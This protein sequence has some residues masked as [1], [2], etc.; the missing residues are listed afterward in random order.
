LH[1]VSEVVELRGDGVV[2]RIDPVDGGRIVSLVIGGVERILP[3]A[4]AR[5]REPALYWGCY[6]MVPWAGPHFERPHPDE[7]R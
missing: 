6:A 2:L 4:R 5:A 3:K 7:G 1:H